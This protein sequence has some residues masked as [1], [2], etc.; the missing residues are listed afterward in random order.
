M[1][2]KIISTLIF[3]L[4]FSIVLSAQFLP[5][6]VGSNAT[7][8]RSGQTGI[9]FVDGTDLTNSIGSLGTTRFLVRDGLMGHLETGQFG[10]FATT[11]TWSA[12]GPSGGMGAGA[13]GFITAANA[14]VGV[15]NLI[16]DELILGWGESGP[17]KNQNY[18][19]LNSF[20]GLAGNPKTVMF[21][22][23]RGAIGINAEPISAIYVDTRNNLLIPSSENDFGGIPGT[24][25]IFKSITIENDQRLSSGE[26]IE[27][28]SS[29]GKQGNTSLIETDVVVEGFRSQIPSFSEAITSPGSDGVAINAQVV[30][31]RQGIPNTP[32]IFTTV[33]PQAAVNQ[34]Y[35]EIAWQDFN[36]LDDVTDA[37]NPATQEQKKL[38]FSFRNG[39]PGTSIPNNNSFSAQNKKVIATMSGN[40]RFG[41]NTTNPVCEIG[42]TPIFFTVIGN[43]YVSGQVFQGSDRRFKKNIQSIDNAMDKIRLMQGTTYEMK[44]EEFPDM[45]FGEGTQYGFI[46]QDLAEVLPEVTG[47]NAAGYYSVNYS[48]IIPVLTQALKE[49]DETM[50]EMQAQ[51]NELEAIIKNRPNEFNGGSFELRQNRPNPASNFT[52]I[53]YR[54]PSDAE[55][56]SISIY[57]LNG[58]LIQKFE[59]NDTSG[60]L[61]VNLNGFI[62]GMYIYDLQ[63]NGEILTTRKMSISKS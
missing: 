38:F 50:T 8:A 15:L 35:A 3:T 25:Q 10:D 48:M 18:F 11:N 1:K 43:S 7:I 12:L 55:N 32:A 4:L 19:R 9:G 54:L 5:G 14:K 27:S 59:L 39:Q 31:D 56:P 24:A 45:N 63:V 30:K 26:I 28:G 20:N 62:D 44:T 51:I 34:Q 42:T 60:S 49:Q 29:M 57:D 2:I 13:Y 21:A 52:I 46:A 36:F 22:N 17:L 33:S 58:R 47:Q 61:N 40:G 23:P 37:C 16:N 6:G 53:E 41:V